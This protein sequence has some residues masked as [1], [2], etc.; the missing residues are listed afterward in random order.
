MVVGCVQLVVVVVV[1]VV[2]R[3]RFEGVVRGG[4]L[5]GGG[6]RGTRSE[7]CFCNG[8]CIVRDVRVIAGGDGGGEGTCSACV[9]KE[10]FRI[11]D[12]K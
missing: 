3:G 12:V 6:V 2:L 1:V 9:Y 5:G 10:C 8:L 4:V 11:V 7:W